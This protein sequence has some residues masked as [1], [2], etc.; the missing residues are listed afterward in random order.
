MNLTELT[1]FLQLGLWVSS[2]VRALARKLCCDEATHDMSFSE[3]ISKLQYLSEIWLQLLLFVQSNLV[4]ANG[5]TR[6][7]YFQCFSFVRINIMISWSWVCHVVHQ[8][9]LNKYFLIQIFDY[10][11]GRKKTKKRGGP[12]FSPTSLYFVLV[13]SLFLLLLHQIS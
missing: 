11:F 10:I 8:Y 6:L 3:T 2:G 12:F 5:G 9:S 1:T 7:R 13:S 4:S